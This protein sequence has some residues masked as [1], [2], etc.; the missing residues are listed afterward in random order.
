MKKGLIAFVLGLGFMSSL[1]WAGNDPD[2]EGRV[3]KVETIKN[4]LT[5]KNEL[6]NNIGPREYRIL[7]KQGMIN[8]YKK[9]DKLKVWL[10]ADRKEAKR[11]E[12]IDR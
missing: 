1:A 5:V 8:D 9:N 3:T 10:M 6:K 7:V 2:L 12:R 11:I 4:V